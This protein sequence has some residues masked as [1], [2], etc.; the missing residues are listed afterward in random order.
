MVIL[1]E[2]RVFIIVSEVDLTAN[3][4]HTIYENQNASESI[5]RLVLLKPNRPLN[6]CLRSV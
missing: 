2:K 6:E 1:E 4:A 3:L 5:R